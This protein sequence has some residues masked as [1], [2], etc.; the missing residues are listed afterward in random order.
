MRPRDNANEVH[1]EEAAR[2][3]PCVTS[4]TAGAMATRFI[5]DP[6]RSS[7]VARRAAGSRSLSLA[8]R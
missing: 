8:A 1:P 3:S 4:F 5:E 7:A 6:P 2:K